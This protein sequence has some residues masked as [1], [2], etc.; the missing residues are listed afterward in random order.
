[1]TPRADGATR[2]D[3]AEATAMLMAGA[4]LI[5]LPIFALLDRQATA[6]V[7]VT[8]FAGAAGVA[9][10]ALG[11]RWFL[12]EG[13]ALAAFEGKKDAALTGGVVPLPARVRLVEAKARLTAH[14][15][16]FAALA[17]GALLILFELGAFKWVAVA[18]FAVSFIADHL[19]L[20]PRPWFLEDGQLRG[21]GL[22]FKVTVPWSEVQTVH[23]RHYPGKRRPPFP[24]GERIIVELEGGEDLEF[25]FHKRYGGT[26]A[27]F[28]VRAMLPLLGDRVRS[29][30]PREKRDD[31]QSPPLAAAREDRAKPPAVVRPPLADETGEGWDPKTTLDEPGFEQEA[32]AHDYVDPEDSE[33]DIPQEPPV[34]ADESNSDLEATLVEDGAEPRP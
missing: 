30:R 10:G 27:S 6:W 16:R 13:P 24:G 3:L 21:G 34:S 26:N 9:I 18:L 20:R 14:A 29:L 15:L 7:W 28:V 33:F 1:V 17:G 19:L 11:I 8:A 5:F 31:G 22:F 25:V 32:S 12:V 23:W 4:A 2:G